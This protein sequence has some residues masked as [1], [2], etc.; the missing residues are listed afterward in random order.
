MELKT[1]K[2][3]KIEKPGRY[4]SPF[5]NL[6]TNKPSKPSVLIIF[7]D[8]FEV[9]QSHTGIK[10]LYELFIQHNIFVDFCFSA[11]KEMQN[12]FEQEGGYKSLMH[13]IPIKEFDAIFVSFQYQ[14]QYPTFLKMLQ[15][16]NISPLKEQRNKK[17]PLIISGGPVMSNPEPI[18][19][20]VDFAFIGEIEPVFSQIITALK[21]STK[22][23]IFEKISQIKGFFNT[24]IPTQ[25]VEKVIA[26][27][28]DLEVPTPKSVPVFGL[29]TVHDRFTVEIQRGCTQGCRFCLAGMFYRPHRERSASQ[30]INTIK[31]NAFN[32][33]YL[34]AGFLSLSAGDHSQIETILEETAKLENITLSLPSLRTETIT[35]NIAQLMTEG[36]KTGFTLAPESGSE[37]LRRVINKGNTKEDLIQ[38]VK[39]IFNKGWRKVKL[40]FMLGLPLEEDK[41][42]FETVELIKE[43]HSIVRNY[44]RKASLN[45]SF[46]TFVP[47][48]F[49]PFQ[50]EKMA[51][52][53]EI[54]Q[55]QKI[56]ISG[57]RRL[58][59]L[60]LSWHDKEISHIEGMLSRSGKEIGKALLYISKKM[61][62]SQ[63]SDKDFDFPL[64]L[65]AFE[66][67][68]ISREKEIGARNLEE[69]LPYEHIS[70][71]ITK[72]FLLKERELAYKAIE[73]PD[74]DQG[75]CT[76][77]GVCDFKTIK[78]IRKK[79]TDKIIKTTQQQKEHLNKGNAIPLLI[80]FS[81]KGRA[82]S[83]GHLD[84]V[85]FLIKGFAV[86][87]VQ[88]LFSEGFHPKPRIN[89]SKPLSLGI[90][91]EN[92]NLVLWVTE[93]SPTMLEDLNKVFK[94][95]GIEFLEITVLI[96][97][98]VKKIEKTLRESIAEYKI[99]F[100][101][102]EGFE[103]FEEK[104]S[105]LIDFSDKKSLTLTFSLKGE[106]SALK[107]FEEINCNYHI[108]RKNIIKL[109]TLKN[110]R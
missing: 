102:I 41:D 85:N 63:T 23:K 75:K 103:Q 26:S 79:T 94:E 64:W 2:I 15:I 50:W 35:E 14:L 40:Y 5:F 55:K 38:A 97:D 18:A 57:L 42:L 88:M 69:T 87:K 58:K 21:E 100:D 7:P 93:K 37:R 22:E 52:L 108:T 8:L 51:T 49:T 86:A 95:T 24:Q 30:I 105:Q 70:L 4:F 106:T 9:A 29:R 13:N 11:T 104:Y 34:E 32:S 110:F 92:E 31:E 28:L 74:C 19:D 3:R 25:K 83:L 60:K 10:I 109:E 54:E 91:S 12:I 82:I 90:E 73:T 46:S 36:R 72:D 84:T 56:I 101:Q 65:E 16:S 53:E 39:F 76:N 43:I 62:E 44:G 78:P 27:D 71:G 89:I 47:Q 99:I 61:E 96:R 67:F 6:V 17:D 68:H 59:N 98:E 81:K 107:F 48:P 77:C 80:S 1:S 45:V 66:K 20:F 33:G